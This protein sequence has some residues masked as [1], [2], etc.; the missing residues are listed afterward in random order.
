MKA[1]VKHQRKSFSRFLVSATASGSGKTTLSLGLL[2]ALKNRGISVQPFKCGPDYIDTK[3]H[4]L[5]AGN[6]S[7]NLDS[8]LAS[9]NHVKDIFFSNI[10]NKD[11]AVVEGVMGL[12]DGYDKMK[13]SSALMAELLD[14]PVILMIP[15]KAMAHSAAAILYGFKHYYPKVKIAGAI[16]NFVK[17]ESHYQYLK[18][19][20][21]EAG[22]EPLGYMPPDESINIPSRHLGLTLDT[23]YRFEQFADYVADRLERHVNI[24]RLLEITRVPAPIQPKEEAPPVSSV[25]KLRISVAYDDAF[26]FVYHE[27]I[28]RLKKLGEVRMFSPISD[29]SLPDSDLI[30][31]PGGYPEL[32]LS[33]L[34]GNRVLKEQIKEYVERGGKVIA[35]C[36]G[37]MYLSRSIIDKDGVKYPMVGIFP[38]D[39]TFQDMKLALGY[40][41]FEYNGVVF[42]GHEFHYSRLIDVSSATE[43]IEMKNAKGDCVN[44]KL[45]RYKN[46]IAGYTHIYWADK[47]VLS[48]FL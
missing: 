35:E 6:P 46:A 2:R 14:L 10:R 16:F 20:C 38:Q 34:S 3:Y 44:T 48:L 40:R 11:V 7:I 27:N 36:G 19:A 37:M 24:E 42:K 8:F 26:N 13:G 33:S 21:L 4:D 28:Q 23:E 17:T 39:A 5:A 22:V 9:S 25:G 47:D 31:F 29:V 1:S 12:F 45:F 32:F 15:A 30:Y 18:E 41:Q 43:N